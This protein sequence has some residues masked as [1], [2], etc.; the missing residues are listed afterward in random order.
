MV[1][2]ACVVAYA[3]TRAASVS[4]RWGRRIAQAVAL[5]GVAVGLVW[6]IPR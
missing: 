2:F 4:V 1:L 6:L 5:T 3:M